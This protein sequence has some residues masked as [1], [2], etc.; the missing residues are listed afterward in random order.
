M[1]TG[2]SRASGSA[3]RSRAAAGPSGSAASR[4]SSAVPSPRAVALQAVRRV[5]DE[6]AYSNLVVPALLGRSGL[7]LRDRDLAAEL[8]YG[9]LRRLLRLDHAL[10]PLLDRPLARASPRARAALRVGAYQLLF[11][12]IPDHAAVAETVAVLPPREGGFAN[13]VLRRLAREGSPEPAGAGPGSIS[14]RTGLARWAVEELQALLGEEAEAAAAGVAEQGPLSLR[15]NPCR[16]D[17]GRLAAALREA[18]HQPEPGRVHPGSL[19][20]AGG[21]PADLPGFADGWFAVQDEASAYVVDVLAPRPGELVLDAASGPGGKAADIACRAGAVVAA[22][23]SDRRA[24]L[25]ARTA[26]RLGVRARLVVQDARRP[27]LRE[28]TFDRVLVDAPCSGI[29]AARRRPELLWRPTRRA[30]RALAR[31]QLGMLAGMAPLVRPGGVLV[32]SVCTFPR[33]ETD[34]VCDALLARAPDLVAERF[35]GPGGEETS[36][37]RLWP[38]RHGTDAMFVARFRKPG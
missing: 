10:A 2:R 32:Y 35:P 9:T 12:R 31:L 11:T 34:D 27:A 26:A 5:T 13:A 8:A 33:V 16:T 18:G 3:R 21:V 14:L 7:P 36:R 19:R 1:G 28:G 37:A 17:V 23:V 20:L 6:G 25:V 24:A 38:H 15:A 29:G 22:D 4:P 30:A